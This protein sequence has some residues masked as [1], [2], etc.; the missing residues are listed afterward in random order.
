MGNL[1]NQSSVNRNQN[2]RKQEF[3]TNLDIGELSGISKQNLTK[4]LLSGFNRNTWEI[5]LQKQYSNLANKKFTI[6]AG[7]GKQK[8]AVKFNSNLILVYILY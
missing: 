8:L 1:N 3:E 6:L 7:N 4:I 2:L 5:S